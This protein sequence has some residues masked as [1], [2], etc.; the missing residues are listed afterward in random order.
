MVS[1]SVA[2][3]RHGQARATPNIEPATIEGV[4]LA[5][6]SAEDSIL[7]KLEWS[8]SGESER[9][10]RDAASILA[11]QGDELNWEYLERWALELGVTDLLAEV[12]RRWQR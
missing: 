9:Q 8:P 6:V 11:V 5:V 10:L 7:S 4:S 3:T 2:S 1:G 12:R